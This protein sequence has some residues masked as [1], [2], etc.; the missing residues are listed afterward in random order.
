MKITTVPTDQ[1]PRYKE[2]VIPAYRF[3]LEQPDGKN[4][5]AVAAT[6]EGNKAPIGF[7]LGWGAGNQKEF[8]LVSLY[9]NPLIRK[10]G[11]GTELLKCIEQYFMEQ[12]FRY[13]VHHLSF[14]DDDQGYAEFL[15]GQGWFITRIKQVICKSTLDLAAETPWLMRARLPERY[16]IKPWHEIS[17]DDRL[18]IQKRHQ[19]ETRTTGE[20]GWYAEDQNPFDKEDDCHRE[21]SLALLK[22]DE[23]VGWVITHQ[24]AEL[25]TS[26]R[27]TISFVSPD[28]Q[29][30]ARILPLWKE[31]Y[32]RQRQH[33]DRQDFIWTVPID[34]PR[35]L[36]FAKRHMRPWLKEMRYACTAVK[37]LG[38]GA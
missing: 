14:P 3:C 29:G 20:K 17:P 21:T 33:T 32:L 25:P 34:H 16:T 11:V 26:L 35:M 24:P 37:E 8:E 28:I 12:Q 9:V 13:G 10:Q 2:F 15:N 23:V 19:Q 30:A 27:W 6:E 7:A 4:L 38:K 36:K 5:Y 1:L 22:E 31:V 18:H